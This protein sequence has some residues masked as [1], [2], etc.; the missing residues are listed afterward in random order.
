MPARHVKKHRAA[1]SLLCIGQ[2]EVHLLDLLLDRPSA[3]KSLLCDLP[4][5][6]QSRAEN[7]AISSTCLLRRATV[8]S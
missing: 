4:P 3:M 8:D 7:T 6:I 2:R 1:K 5:C